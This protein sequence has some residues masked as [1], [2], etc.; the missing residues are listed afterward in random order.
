MS[1]SIEKCLVGAYLSC[2]GLNLPCDS[3]TSLLPSSLIS[4]C[5]HSPDI[6]QVFIFNSGKLL[7]YF[8][9]FW[10]GSPSRCRDG[11]IS[12][13]CLLLFSI[14]FCDPLF[15]SL[16]TSPSLSPTLIY[17][18]PFSHFSHFLLPLSPF[19]PLSAFFLS[20][21]LSLSLS[22]LVPSHILHMPFTEPL[23]QIFFQLCSIHSHP[24]PA[25]THTHN[26]ACPSPSTY[27]VL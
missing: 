4:R 6:H 2:F 26:A 13:T 14:L 20:L 3:P 9:W 18:L 23:F 5:K 17:P 22:S 21:S 25:K 8:F 12:T 1:F 27:C 16:S 15:L 11:S 19:A 24:L 10:H 7:S